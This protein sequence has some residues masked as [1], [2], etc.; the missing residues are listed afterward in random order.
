MRA[1]S[2][3][4]SSRWVRAAVPE[5]GGRRIRVNAPV[6]PGSAPRVKELHREKPTTTASTSSKALP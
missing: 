6:R 5:P 4:D 3:I 2:D 1:N